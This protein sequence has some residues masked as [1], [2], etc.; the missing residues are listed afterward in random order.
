M[1]AKEQL[2]SWMEVISEEEDPSNAPTV[3]YVEKGE[4]PEEKASKKKSTKKAVKK[5]EEP[6]AESDNSD[7]VI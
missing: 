2:G 5:V 1:T 4:L 3:V 6:K 7:I